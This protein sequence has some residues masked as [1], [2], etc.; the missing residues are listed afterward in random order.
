MGKQR[1]GSRS[2]SG[3]TLM[4]WNKS[5]KPY[6]RVPWSMFLAPMEQ[7]LGCKLCHGFPL[8]QY[9]VVLLNR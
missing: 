7:S 6:R 2:D 5:F 9:I 3:E 4:L 1:D 8:C